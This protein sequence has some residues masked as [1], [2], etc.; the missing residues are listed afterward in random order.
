MFI[1]R[2]SSKPQNDLDFCPIFA[3]SNDSKKKKKKKGAELYS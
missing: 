2:N 1:L 3:E